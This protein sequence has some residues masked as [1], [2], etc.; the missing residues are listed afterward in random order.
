MEEDFP[1]VGLRLLMPCDILVF[2][3]VVPS[4]PTLQ[5]FIAFVHHSCIA[6]SLCTLNV[7]LREQSSCPESFDIGHSRLHELIQVERRGFVVMVAE[8][9]TID[10]L[11]TSRRVGESR[12]ELV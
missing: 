5:V 7:K 3:M 8:D 10:V 6:L 11:L 1:K 4:E 2:G 12:A 9:R